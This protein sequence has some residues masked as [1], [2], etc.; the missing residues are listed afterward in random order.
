MYIHYIYSL[1]SVNMLIPKTILKNQKKKNILNQ[2]R[3]NTNNSTNNNKQKKVRF[4]INLNKV[5]KF[6]SSLEPITISN[7]NSPIISPVL[8][9]LDISSS[10]SD[11][12]EFPESCWFNNLNVLPSLVSFDKTFNSFY[13]QDHISDEYLDYFA[14]GNI[15]EEEED[16][17]QDRVDN[18][19]DDFLSM[20]HKEFHSWK[21]ISMNFTPSDKYQSDTFI[22]LAS[23]TQESNKVIGFLVVNNL[24]FEK[25]IEVK[26]TFNNWENIHYVNASFDRSIDSKFDR[27]RFT[28]D[29]DRYKFFLN[30][31]NLIGDNE[32]KIN[33]QF[34]CKYDVNNET[35]YDNNDYQNY[36]IQLQCNRTSPPSPRTSLTHT[37]NTNSNN[38]QQ[39][40]RQGVPS[41][42][43]TFSDDT[44]YFNSSPLKH[45]YH[46]IEPSKAFLSSPNLQSLSNSI[47]NSD[48][49]DM[50]SL[51]STS[52]LSLSSSLSS[53][54]TYSFTN[55]SGKTKD[56]R[57]KNASASNSNNN[58][59]TLNHYNDLEYYSNFFSAPLDGSDSRSVESDSTLQPT[60]TNVA[61]SAGAS[62]TIKATS[63]SDYKNLMESYCFYPTEQAGDS[64]TQ[65][66]L[67]NIKS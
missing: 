36:N 41:H 29:L 39:T 13:M 42:S 23:I 50:K 27:F 48:H 65:V 17:D 59:K 57:G 32:S 16:V 62:P 25:L 34:C 33:L 2:R 26:F 47:N 35:Y 31:K 12:E 5:K 6:D 58:Y 4:D 52:D 11:I 63:T 15:E 54:S 7:E 20:D 22:K 8:L 67:S 10:D 53:S 9:P 19:E 24:N 30:F 66:K 18:N 40:S 3:N 28:I 45:L 21:V 37:P 43:R 14:K 60:Q 46:G 49:L 64:K 51:S 38:I 44:D 55:Y 1:I 56:D 61:A